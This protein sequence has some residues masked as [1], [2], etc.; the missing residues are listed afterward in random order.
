MSPRVVVIAQARMGSSRLPGKVLAEASGRSLLEH[1]LRR[2]AASRMAQA[3]VIATTTNATDDVLER[4]AR[5]LGAG[6]FRGSEDDVLARYLG[7]AAASRADVIVRVTADCPLLDPHEVDRVISEYLSRLGR[8]DEVDYAS[9]Q[10]GN[11]RR[12]PRGLD[13]E[14]MSRA[15]LE[16]AGREAVATGDREHVTPYLYREPGRFRTLVSHYPGGDYSALRL[17]VDTPADLA[18]VR[19][20]TA[21]LGPDASL[22]AIAEL[23][24]Q[25]PELAALNAGVAQKS[26]AGDDELRRARIAGRLLV[27]RADA[28]PSLGY[29]HV[30]RLGALLEA[31]AAA[32]GSAVLAGAG[33]G[34][35]LRQRFAETIAIVDEPLAPGALLERFPQAA[36][37]A[38]D[39]YHFGPE[40]E[41]ALR[42][43]KPL[44]VFDDLGERTPEGDLIL[45]QNLGA[46]A[47][48]YPDAPGKVLAGASYTLFR[49]E[50]RVA[51]NRERSAGARRVL[52]AFGGSD[53]LTLSGSVAR[54]LLEEL[55]DTRVAVVVGPAFSPAQRAE[56]QRLAGIHA[57]LELVEDPPSMAEVFASA[58]AAVLG[59]GSSAWDALCLGVPCV[60]VAVADNQRPVLAGAVQAGAALGV[61]VAGSG[62]PGL[63]L[64]AIARLLDDAALAAELSE[65][66]RRL[67]D[68]RGCFRVIDALLDAIERRT[69]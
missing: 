53:P 68:G 57:A 25:R 41:R 27:G 35:R 4:E 37:V 59:A 16:R 50:L 67:F 18:L 64:D 61:G 69:G 19:A 17:T 22:P 39:G 51:R 15:A 3:T 66:G 48:A 14:V 32:G 55:P 8:S 28:G 11:E 26:I 45:N 63:V 46:S 24:A 47:D 44:L 40:T 21:E 42:A 34:G 36:A 6:V 54:R 1:L 23:L 33:L 60:L 31:W 30:A 38:L 9:N 7:A 12:I 65:R 2:L 43:R 56:L 29:G 5:R 62:T 20:I 10:A 49:N 52:C 13:V 58:S